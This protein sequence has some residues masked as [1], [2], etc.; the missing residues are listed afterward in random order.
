M[1]ETRTRSRRT[2]SEESTRTPWWASA[3]VYQI[4]LR[5]FRDTNG[6][7]IGDLNGVTEK[8]D[9]IAALGVDA[10]WLTPFYKSPMEDYGY[11]IAD[12]RSVDPVF[13][14]IEDLDRLVMA[15]RER[16]LRTIVDFTPCHTSKEH[17]WFRE[18]RS[19]RD[20]PKADWYVWGDAR[21]DGAPPSNYLSSFGG[22]AW[23]WEPR[24]SQYR[25]H[26]FLDCQPNLNLH[27]SEVVDA[28]LGEM[29]FWLDRGI[30][31][32]RLDAVQCLLCDLDLR[33]NPPVASTGPSILVGGGPHNPFRQQEH[34]FDRGLPQS[35][36]VFARMR[37][38]VDR[39]GEDRFLL[40]EA[41]DV[42]SIPYCAEAT[43][44]GRLHAA[45]HFDL[46]NSD[47][48]VGVLRRQI[49]ETSARPD[50]TIMTVA[51]NQ[52]STRL[53]SN[54]GL[55][56]SE[57]GYGRA[58]AR[59]MLAI[60]ATQKGGAVVFQGE[61]LGLTEAE[62]GYED[63]R[64]PWGLHLYPD[65]KG[66]DGCRTPMPWR[67]DAPNAGFG[68]GKPWLPVAQDH[69]PLAVDRQEA[70]P[71]SVL[72]AYRRFLAWRREQPALRGGT[73]RL[74]DEAPEPLVVYERAANGERLLC[75][76]N[77]AD[78]PF[79]WRLPEAERAGW[80]VVG[81]HGL[82]GEIRSGGDE[83]GVIALGPYDGVFARKRG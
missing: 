4:Y 35:M 51:G 44:P 12:F 77:L 79:T 59:T 73:Q 3:I 56:P 70:D 53:M 64:D 28:I 61:E 68:E 8:L 1:S 39:Y 72:N 43:A 36:H 55:R 18:S 13:G 48:D 40:G 17:A 66:R 50:A 78:R 7:G 69:L 71:D 52:D 23:T 49:R 65:F 41:S 80:K 47:L 60:M 2:A 16:G 76:F 34:V 81:G 14:E 57:Q 11:D 38:L 24:R 74:L 54:W 31:G 83:D 75:A 62:L 27:N 46:I 63:L 32:I 20:D 25:Y 10:L 22:S 45:Y 33:D 29:A 19:S 58:F 30:D 5:S 42:D 82:G 37:A 26:A 21:R 67:A 9:Y 15:A 6:D